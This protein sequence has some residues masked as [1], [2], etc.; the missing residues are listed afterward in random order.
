MDIKN[1]AINFVS[2]I[3]RNISELEKVPVNMEVKV[4]VVNEGESSEFSYDYIEVDGEEYRLPKIVLKQLQAQLKEKP[5]ITFFKV[6]K[7]GTTKNNT[8]YTVIILE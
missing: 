1:S 8:L 6:N 3:T 5:D 4:K 2:K 7:E